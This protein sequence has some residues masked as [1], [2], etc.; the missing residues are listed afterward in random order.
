MICK[1]LY[2]SLMHCYHVIYH[3]SREQGQYIS[4]IHKQLM[5]NWFHGRQLQNCPNPVANSVIFK[6]AQLLRIL[7]TQNE[8]RVVTVTQFDISTYSS[9][10]AT[11][12]PPTNTVVISMCLTARTDISVE[13]VC[14]HTFFSKGGHLEI[15]MLQLIEMCRLRRLVICLE[16]KEVHQPKF[17]CEDCLFFGFM[18]IHTDQSCV[19]G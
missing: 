18:N 4:L 9:L 16:Y 12:I 2:N 15:H 13:R 5:H 11:R 6:Y 17:M 7:L 1:L 3:T 14:V 19:N 10:A 8:I